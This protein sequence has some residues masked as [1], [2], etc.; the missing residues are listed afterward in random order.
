MMSSSPIVLSYEYEEDGSD[1]GPA[2][3]TDT[4][5]TNANNDSSGSSKIHYRSTPI[6]YLN[7]SPLPSSFTKRARPNQTLLDF[8][9]NTVGLTG[10]K[11][12]CGE[13]GCG[14]CT[15][16]ISRY[17]TSFTTTSTSTSTSTTSTSSGGQKQHWGRIGH[18]TVNA[19]LFPVLAAD[20]CHITTIE[21]VGSWRSKNSKMLLMN[22]ASTQNDEDEGFHHPHQQEQHQEEKGVQ[23]T[24]RMVCSFI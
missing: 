14:A 6:I 24:T 18:T 7:G 22:N 4:D 23:S 1:G 12:G 17:S 15:V 20:G 21:G 13:G 5:T 10:S 19:C 9:R 8:L 16:L 3:D 11:L 2:V